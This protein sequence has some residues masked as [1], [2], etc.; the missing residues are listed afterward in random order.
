MMMAG[1]SSSLSASARSASATTSPTLSASASAAFAAASSAGIS[2]RGTGNTSS[3]AVSFCAV[4]I[5]SSKAALSKVLSASFLAILS[6]TSCEAMTGFAAILSAKVAERAAPVWP[7]AD[8]GT[9]RTEICAPISAA[10]VSYCGPSAPSITRLSRSQIKL[11]PASRS[12]S[13]SSLN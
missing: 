13:F 9:T 1:T 6:T 10:P 12:P 4:V 3:D 11:V 2:G 5:A 8:R 7:S